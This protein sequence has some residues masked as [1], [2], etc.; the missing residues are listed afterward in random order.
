MGKKQN[1]KSVVGSIGICCSAVRSFFG[2]S[3][4]DLCK[5]PNSPLGTLLS[6]RIASVCF[7]SDVLLQGRGK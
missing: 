1:A 3:L 4:V 2:K 7:N 6:G 5:K